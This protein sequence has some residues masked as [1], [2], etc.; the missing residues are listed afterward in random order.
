MIGPKE[1]IPHCATRPSAAS[2]IAMGEDLQNE[3]LGCSEIVAQWRHELHSIPELGLSTPETTAYIVRR[4]QEMGLDPTLGHAGEVSV[5]MGDATG[6]CILLRADMDGLPIVEKSGEPWSA[7][8]GRA[9][10]CGHDMHA[11][12]LLGA[13]LMLKKRERLVRDL[14][15]CVKLLFQPGEETLEGAKAAIA[16]G[17]LESPRVDVAFAVHVNGRCPMGLMLYGEHQ[18]A[19]VWGFRIR[20]RGR[21]GHGS[22]PEKCIDPIAAGAHVHLAVNEAMQ[23]EFP[24]GSE[25]VLS[26]GQF[27][28]GSAANVI[29]DECVMEGTARAFDMVALERIKDL[30]RAVVKETS[31]SC[32]AVA[33]ID[34]LYSVPPLVVDNDMTYTSLSYVGFVLPDMR[35]RG[36]QHTLGAEDF[37]LFSEQVPAAYFTVGAAVSDSNEHYSMHDA[38]VRFDDAALPVCAAAYCAVALGWLADAGLRT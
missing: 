22:A 34:D 11:A 30:V 31:A 28:S 36:I 10:A 27:H 19:G 38:R 33:E 37:A 29:P 23:R 1:R 16:D 17:I 21:G 12:S 7:C 2:V 5:V 25:A 32:L 20:L 18:S 26:I 9:H 8:C 24:P 15:G 3:A 6:P 14:G 35:F 4:L 13:A